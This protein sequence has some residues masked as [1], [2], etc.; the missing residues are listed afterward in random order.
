[1]FVRSDDPSQPCLLIEM[2]GDWPTSLDSGVGARVP[3][4]AGQADGATAPPPAAIAARRHGPLSDA[5]LLMPVSGRAAGSSRPAITWVVSVD[6][7]SASDIEDCLASL[8]LQDGAQ[9][10]RLT[11]IHSSPPA[12]LPFGWPL[13]QP[14][15][16]VATIETAI[17][18]ADTPLIGFI[19]PEIV[20]HDHHTA[21]TLAAVAANDEAASASCV[22]IASDQHGRNWHARLADVAGL[23]LADRSARRHI[24]QAVEHMWR[25][26][27]PVTAPCAEL[28]LAT[29]RRVAAWF[30]APPPK[31][32]A[33]TFHVCSALTTASHDRPRRRGAPQF[34]PRAPEHRTMRVG[35]LFG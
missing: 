17:R 8:A 18:E 26:H 10:D 30:D 22:L 15:R 19:A 28:W 14:V 9:A 13:E 3:R 34:V 35:V 29:T 25:N 6:G 24:E 20:L 4:L 27:F 11:I 32:E 5:E 1:L 31:L 16:F 12:G 7:A 21:A 2:P 33:N 23:A